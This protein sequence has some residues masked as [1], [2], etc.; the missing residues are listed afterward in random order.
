MRSALSFFG[1]Q[2]L[3]LGENPAVLRLFKSF[4]RLNPKLPRYVVSWP[5][6]SFLEFLSSWHPH[7][8]L[9]LRQ[10]TL[11]TLA[12]IAL[13]S[14][15]RGQT[16]HKMDIESTHVS[17]DSISFVILEPL[18]TTHIKRKPKVVK[19]ISSDIAALNV[20]DYTLVYMNRTL[21]LRAAQ[22][23]KGKAKPTKLFLSWQTKAPVSKQTIGRWLKLILKIAG[24]DTQQFSGHSFR[25]AGLNSALQHGASI[26][27]ILKAGDWKSVNTFN[28]YYNKPDQSTTVGKL[29]LESCKV[30]RYNLNF[31][32]VLYENWNVTLSSFI[33]IANLAT[34]ISERIISFC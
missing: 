9:S 21:A 8:S 26:T 29:I 27:E 17:G 1:P 7:K 28:S 31:F 18:K 10:L 22:V 4:Y 16:L 2:N 11:K 20:C 19:C 24:I 12:L 34:H 33:F 5:V 32:F 15:D 13:T 14:S 3:K 6:K 25:S 23:K 30:C